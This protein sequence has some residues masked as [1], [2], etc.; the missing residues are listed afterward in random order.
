MLSISAII[1]LEI[2][3]LPPCPVWFAFGVSGVTAQP[4]DRGSSYDVAPPFQGQATSHHQ[5]T[6][7]CRPTIDRDL[8]PLLFSPLLSPRLS[9]WASFESQGAGLGRGTLLSLGTHFYTSLF[10]SPIFNAKEQSTCRTRGNSSKSQIP[11]KLHYSSAKYLLEPLVVTTPPPIPC[12][13]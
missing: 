7:I 12:Q 1:S 5:S 8:A 10:T 3:V 4:L 9:A 13:R 11:I 6:L 2:L